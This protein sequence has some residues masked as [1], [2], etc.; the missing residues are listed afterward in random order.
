MRLGHES[1]TTLLPIDDELDLRPVF[2]E[3]IQHR[4]KALTWHTKSVGDSLFN[5]ALNQ[6]VATVLGGKFLIHAAIVEDKCDFE[7]I[8]MDCANPEID[9][10]A[11]QT[12]AVLKSVTAGFGAKGFPLIH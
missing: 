12:S 9:Y 10:S 7:G 2:V 4:K 11:I 1:G 8:C 5:Q 6:Q 3:A